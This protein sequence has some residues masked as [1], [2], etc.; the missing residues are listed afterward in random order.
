[1]NKLQDAYEA[2]AKK[3]NKIE[4]IKKLKTPMSVYDRLDEIASSTLE[5]LFDE[6][7]SFFLKCFGLFLKKDGKFMLRIRIPAGALSCE[8]AQKIGELS[9]L[10]GDDYIDI[11]TRQQIELRYIQL[12]NISTVLKE[13]DSVGI[14]TFQTGVDNFRNIVTSSMDGLGDT[15]IVECK[16]IIDE[17]QLLFFKKEEWIGKLPRK[18]NTA[19]LGNSINDCNIYGHDCCFIVASCDGEIGFNLYLGGK[20]GVQAQDCGL[21]L[22]KEQVVPTFKAIVELF[23][24]YG[25]RDN[26]NKNRLHFLLEAVGMDEFVKAIKEES[27]IS[28]KNSGDILAKDEFVLDSGSIYKLNDEINAYHL[29]IPSGV[30][31]G[32]DLIKVASLCAKTDSFIRLSVEQSLYIISASKNKEEILKSDIYSSYASYQNIYFNHQ[33]ACAGTATCSFG[34]IPNK[35]DAIEMA[36]FLQKEVPLEDGKVR[37][38]WSACPKGCGIH[39]VADIGF[40]GCK[41]KDDDGDSCYGVHIYLGGKATKEA[42]EARVLYKAIPLYEAKEKVKGLMIYYKNYKKENETFEEFDSR[43]FSDLSVDEII[44]KIKI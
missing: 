9:K 40:E 27:N 11:T 20:V 19:I 10:Y 44:E 31:S 42:K 38:Y 12:K 22:T 7:S 1:M 21:F 26:R 35:P 30:F 43:V 3:T 6:D 15:S 25:F 39:G 32:I 16:P 17:L 24:R 2:R 13:L 5:E 14:S 28:Y 29:S 34:V 33:I 37:M 4:D 41:A 8:Q 23:K 36:E 18:F